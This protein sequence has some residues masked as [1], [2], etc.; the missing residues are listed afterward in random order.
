MSER[1]TDFNR[2][3]SQ[4]EYGLTPVMRAMNATENALLARIAALEKD[5]TDVAVLTNQLGELAIAVNRHSTFHDRIVKLESAATGGVET[6]HRYDPSALCKNCNH[7]LDDHPG[8]VDTGHARCQVLTC[9]CLNYS[10]PS[11]PE[12]RVTPADELSV[13][14]VPWDHVNRHQIW[15]VIR[16]V[17]LETY[18]KETRMDTSVTARTENAIDRIERILGVTS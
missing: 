14:M 3:I 15:C 13:P 7:R 4:L 9:S 16:D 18:R 2:R 17:V 1:D 10:Y 8:N 11:T 5:A 12:P 6:A